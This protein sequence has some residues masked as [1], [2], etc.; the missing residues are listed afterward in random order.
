M[1]ELVVVKFGTG[2]KILPFALFREGESRQVVQ[3]TGTHILRWWMYF[4]HGQEEKE[5]TIY[6]KI[7]NSHI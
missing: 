5:D 6:Y 1:N 3:H 7:T 2:Y 4:M